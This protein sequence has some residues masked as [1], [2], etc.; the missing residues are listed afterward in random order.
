MPLCTH[1]TPPSSSRLCSLLQP[2]LTPCILLLI[3]VCLPHQGVSPTGA[4]ALV[5]FVVDSSST[6][7][8]ASLSLTG[9]QVLV[10]LTGAISSQPTRLCSAHRPPRPPSFL[11]SGS[12]E[13]W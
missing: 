9:A 4:G 13:C 7:E 11:P 10:G 6:P 5:C 3:V 12:L 1:P 2:S 8:R